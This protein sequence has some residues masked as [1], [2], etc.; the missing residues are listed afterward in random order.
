MIAIHFANQAERKG[1]AIDFLWLMSVLA[2]AGAIWQFGLS[3]SAPLLMATPG[4]FLE[5][6]AGV[7]P[8]STTIWSPAAM[9]LVPI[10]HGRRG[11]SSASS[12]CRRS[13]GRYRSSRRRRGSSSEPAGGGR[14][15]EAARRHDLRA[16]ARVQPDRDRRRSRWRS[17]AWIY[18]HFFVRNLSLDIN[19][20]NTIVLLLGVVLHGNVHNFTKA[21]QHA[22]ALV[23]ADRASCTTSTRGSP[24]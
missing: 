6:Q 23:L 18:H 13:R 2:G 9:I 3:G 15:R 5:Q 10:V 17:A 14:R 21:T 8:L 1:I 24:G 7:M 12:S 16:A 22:V 11:R 19:S 20:V 4:N